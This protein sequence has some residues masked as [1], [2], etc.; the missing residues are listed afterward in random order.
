MQALRKS[1]KSIEYTFKY[2]KVIYEKTAFTK[3]NPAVRFIP[4]ELQMSKLKESNSTE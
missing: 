3:F 2:Q 4:S 1:E